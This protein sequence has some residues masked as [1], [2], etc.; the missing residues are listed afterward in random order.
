MATT[1]ARIR[2][3]V[4]ENLE[5]NGLPLELPQDLNI[6]LA[7]LGVSSL[8]MAAFAKRVSAEFN[9]AFTLADCPNVN[10]MQKLVSFVESRSG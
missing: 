10:S 5:I 7:D 3:L 8:D 2:Q 9:I 1:E 4:K 6:S